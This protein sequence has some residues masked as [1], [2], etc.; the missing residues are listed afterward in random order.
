MEEALVPAEGPLPAGGLLPRFGRLPSGVYAMI[1]GWAPQDDGRLADA[2]GQVE[3]GPITFHRLAQLTVHTDFGRVPGFGP[4][5]YVHNQHCAL[6]ADGPMEAVYT[7]FRDWRYIAAKILVV[8][9]AEPDKLILAAGVL[10]NYYEM[11]RTGR[12]SPW[13]GKFTWEVGFSILDPVSM[14]VRW[15]PDDEAELAPIALPPSPLSGVALSEEA[16]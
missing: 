3:H 4:G 15:H 5:G 1:S 2:F 6:R 7:L 14:Q 11:P 8:R 12:A 10:T 13:R 9:A 16:G